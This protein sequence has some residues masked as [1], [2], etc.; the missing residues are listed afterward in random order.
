VPGL[1]EADV[2]VLRHRFDLEP[3]LGRNDHELLCRRDDT[4][5]RRDLELLY[6]PVNV[7]HDVISFHV[8]PPAP[9]A[10]HPPCRPDGDRMADA[11]A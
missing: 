9:A 5:N 11:S 1:D 7:A 10:D 3:I 8:T 2:L 6:D 4:A